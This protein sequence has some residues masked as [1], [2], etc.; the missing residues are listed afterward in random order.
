MDSK[1]HILSTRKLD[2]ELL[3]VA[4][5]KNIEIDVY[6]Y[7]AIHP[8]KDEATVAEIATVA[9]RKC[10]VVFTSRNA[11]DV[12]TNVLPFVPDW[13]IATIGGAT[14]SAVASF[15]GEEKII[16]AAA[17]GKELMEKLV[18]L[19]PSIPIVFFA[20][21]RRLDTIPIGVQDAELAFEEIIVYDTINTPRQETEVYSGI[22]FMSP[23]AVES[24]FS[25]NQIQ[26]EV[27]LF[28]I[29]ETTATS[30]RQKV[31]NKI[32]ISGFHSP[33]QLVQKIIDY[34]S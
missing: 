29:G 21:N 8:K 14:R 31:S 33:Q 30:I 24:F 2:E 10:I 32:I 34:Y 3:R 4:A 28:A 1:I 26:E 19:Q 15:F 20:G 17:T 16:L 27:V 5:A 22:L 23:S 7:I 9:K 18:T 13:Q 6:P 25:C 11:V 12:V